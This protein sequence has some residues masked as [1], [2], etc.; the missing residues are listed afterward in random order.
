MQPVIYIRRTLVLEVLRSIRGRPRDTA[1]GTQGLRVDE[2]DLIE[3]RGD[4][5]DAGRRHT[6]SQRDTYD[7]PWYLRCHI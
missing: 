3:V 2:S 4:T 1:G 7:A 5:G 6:C